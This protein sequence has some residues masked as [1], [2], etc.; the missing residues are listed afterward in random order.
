MYETRGS[1]YCYK[2]TDVLVNKLEIK[3][4]ILLKEY[5]RSI[6]AIKLLELE[7]IQSEGIFDVNHFC[8]IHRFLFEDI[9]NFAGLFRN[10]DIAKDNFKFA[11][12]EYIEEQLVRLFA[13]LE[14]EEYLYGV[15]KDKLAKRLSYYISELN[16]IHPFREGNGR[17]IREFAR[18]L[19]IKNNYYLNF[20]QVSAEKILNASIKSVMDTTDLEN[21]IY[22]C[23][24]KIHN[25]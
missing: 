13:E 16:V 20:N 24:Q 12:W 3:D 5:E 11:R 15:D 10:E 8:N 9:Y 7:K 19:A 1:V 14:R 21:V 23:L 25:D 18:Q 17:T 4:N 6:V 2:D 22:M